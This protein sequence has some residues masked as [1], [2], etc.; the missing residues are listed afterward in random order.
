MSE[1]DLSPS[2]VKQRLDRFKDV[3]GQIQRGL[4]G[5]R[6]YW[7]GAEGGYNVMWA[8]QMGLHL[9][10]ETQIKKRGYRLKRGA[11][12]VGSRY[13]GSPISRQALLYVLECQAVRVAKPTDEATRNPDVAPTPESPF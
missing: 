12:A 3:A 8:E 6:F 1:R 5:D 10:T 13:F 7:N 9:I 11:K 2:E 4:D